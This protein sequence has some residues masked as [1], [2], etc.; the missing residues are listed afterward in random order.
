MDV[1]VV[2]VVVVDENVDPTHGEARQGWREA[3]WQSRIRHELL[4][5]ASLLAI[6]PPSR[7]TL[8]LETRGLTGSLAI[9]STVLSG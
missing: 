2:V 8:A 4:F 7:T 9:P 3:D 6:E 5:A 1:D